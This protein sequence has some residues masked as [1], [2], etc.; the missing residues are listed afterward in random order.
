MSAAGS[1][2]ATHRVG[3]VLGLVCSFAVTG[4]FAENSSDTPPPWVGEARAAAGQLAGRL[5]PTLQAALQSGGPSN[6]I[7]VCSTEAP[8]IA[9]EVSR[10]G[11]EIERTALRVRNPA[12]AAD[13]WEKEVLE[14][15]ERQIRAGAEIA[16]LEAW[17][18]ELRDGREF[19]RW[20][21]PILTAPMC[22]TCHGTEIDAELATTIRTHYPDD[23]A[24]GFRPGELRGAFTA[25]IELPV[26]DRPGDDS[27]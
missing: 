4:A 15:F 14:D 6:G 20:M 19:G 18:V 12:N 27:P 21:K 24:T 9:R 8:A 25:T 23:Q 22:T 1:H 11:F 7:A 10:P 26:H 5:M 17:S 3:A 2:A 16:A 13:A